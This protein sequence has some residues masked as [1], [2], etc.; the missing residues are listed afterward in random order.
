MLWFARPLAS[1]PP[2]ATHKCKSCVFLQAQFLITLGGLIPLLFAVVMEQIIAECQDNFQIIASVA[3]KQQ[4][5]PLPS[6]F[7]FCFFFI[8]SADDGTFRSA[9]SMAPS[10]ELKPIILCPGPVEIQFHHQSVEPA[11]NKDGSS[12]LDSVF[13]W[14]SIMRLQLSASFHAIPERTKKK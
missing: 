14:P 11:I 8:I 7:L 2:P 1:P 13:S 9:S 4:S 10:S 6:L 3:E 12:P 5:L